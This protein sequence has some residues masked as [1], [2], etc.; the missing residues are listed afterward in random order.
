MAA[1]T[2]VPS[3]LRRLKEKGEIN[4][5]RAR[6]GFTGDLVGRYLA[7]CNQSERRD[8]LDELSQHDVPV[9]LMG[10]MLAAYRQYRSRQHLRTLRNH[11]HGLPLVMRADGCILFH[12]GQ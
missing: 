5:R 6:N 1:V 9:A 12:R 10:E 8:W 3:Y 2:E 11:A 4:A 7:N